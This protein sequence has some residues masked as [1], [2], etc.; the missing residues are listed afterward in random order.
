M[1]MNIEIHGRGIVEAREVKKRL[2]KVLSD[3]PW[4]GEVEIT[5]YKTETTDLKG[6]K[7]PF[8]RIY[9]EPKAHLPVLLN[10]LTALGHELRLVILTSTSNS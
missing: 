7:K 5:L 1:S 8:L 3:E 6:R 10:K 4:S 9:T 2:V